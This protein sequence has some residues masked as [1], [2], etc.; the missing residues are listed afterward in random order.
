MRIRFAVAS[1][2]LFATP[3]FAHSGHTAMVAGHT[4][5]LVDLMVMG[6]VPAL[7]VIGGVILALGWAKRRND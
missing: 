5:T 1:A 3:V 4:H 7:L 6:A 2:A